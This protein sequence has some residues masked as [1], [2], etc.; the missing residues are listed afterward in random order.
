M[1]QLSQVYSLNRHEAHLES[2]AH[3]EIQVFLSDQG[4]I[5]TINIHFKVLNIPGLDL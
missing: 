2:L 3:L 1:I 5:T 4:N